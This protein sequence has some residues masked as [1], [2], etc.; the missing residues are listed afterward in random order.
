MRLFYSLIVLLMAH[1]ALAGPKEDFVAAV[2]SQCKKSKTEA[3]A[4]ATPGRSG[5]VMGL[6]ICAGGTVEVDASCKLTCK[7][8][9]GNVVGE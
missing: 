9:S 5:N 1:S 8:Q 4:L 7:S 3:E 2:Q 6:Q